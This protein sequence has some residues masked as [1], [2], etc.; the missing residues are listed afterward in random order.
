MTKTIKITYEGKAFHV[1]STGRYFTTRVPIL[2]ERLLHRIVWTKAF[3]PVPD[4]HEIHH[5]NEDWT[6]NR[7][8]NLEC[9][10]AV[11]HQRDHM[12][13]KYKD[14]AF[15][16]ARL[17]D[18]ESAQIAA[19]AWHSSPEGIEWHRQHG[20]KSW[21]ARKPKTY[22]C[23]CCGLVFDSMRAYGVE[24]CSL[25]CRQKVKF[26][27]DKTSIGT[28]I[29]CGTSFNF[30]KYREQDCCSRSCG[31]KVRGM[32]KRG[33]WDSYKSPSVP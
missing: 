12:L 18:L 27:E 24:F 19:K 31:N 1:Q 7:I 16:A 33:V 29:L 9:I 2:G 20:K 11:K 23:K 17:K 15:M 3:G 22:T 28:C 32:K 21:V 6:D 25:S 13:E 8:E 4:K 5:I 10:D 26:Q 30:N 14:P